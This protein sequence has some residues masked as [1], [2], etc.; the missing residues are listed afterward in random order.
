MFIDLGNSILETLNYIPGGVII[1]SKLPNL[2][3]IILLAPSYSFLGTIISVWTKHSLFIKMNNIKNVYVESNR[4]AAT[5][6]I[7]DNF[8]F[9]VENKGGAIF[10]GISSL[11]NKDLLQLSDQSRNCLILV[12]VPYRP[13][14]DF[15]L[16]LK[17][18]LLNVM[19]HEGLSKVTGNQWY[20]QDASRRANLLAGK[21]I[22]I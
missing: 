22:G 18:D 14:T 21:I 1:L 6:K 10:L 12:G 8:E 11:E 20:Q 7:L 16:R 15:R 2:T 17:M 3:I 4:P 13:W 9:D 19:A 5:K